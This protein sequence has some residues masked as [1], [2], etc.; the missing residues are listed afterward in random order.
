MKKKIIT[1]FLAVI[2]VGSLCFAEETPQRYFTNFNE[3]E[4]KA[5]AEKLSSDVL[6][7]LSKLE[8]K[9][10][11]EEKYKEA[12]QCL[13]VQDLVGL[14]VERANHYYLMTRL[15]SEHDSRKEASLKLL[16]NYFKRYNPLTANAIKVIIKVVAASNNKDVIKLSKEAITELTKLENYFKQAEA[17]FNKT[18][19]PKAK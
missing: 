14:E 7:P 6:I 8:E 10:F 16:H 1:L 11:N 12:C 2:C 17:S 5:I 4:I 15:V 13:M 3:K 9:L 19:F 18:V